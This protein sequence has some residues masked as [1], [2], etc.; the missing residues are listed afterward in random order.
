VGVD[1]S[2]GDVASSPE[3]QAATTIAPTT[4]AAARVRTDVNP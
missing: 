1:G 3:E 4:I 2:V